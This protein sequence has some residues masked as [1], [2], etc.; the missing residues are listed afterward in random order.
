MLAVPGAESVDG[1]TSAE[2]TPAALRAR[3]GRLGL[4]QRELAKLLGV[5]ATTIAR[6]ERGEQVIG[7]PKLVRLA[8][9]HLAE[10]PLLERA[11]PTARRD[12]LPAETSTLVGREAEVAKLVATLQGVRLLTLT[13][14][15]GVGKTRLALRVAAALRD[16]FADGVWLLDVTSLVDA[17]LLSREVTALLRVRGQPGS[18]GSRQLN[19]LLV[20]DNCEHLSQACADVATVLLRACPKLVILCTSRV[21]LGAAGETVYEVPPLDLPLAQDDPSR[22]AR[23]GA[24]RLFVDRARAG[25]H[26]FALTPEN[27]AA[28]AELCGRL[29]GLPLALELAAARMRTL[30]PQQLITRVYESVEPPGS[31]QVRAANRH[32]TMRATLDWSYALV[33]SRAQELLD[34]LSVFA[35]GASLA[36]VESVCGVESTCGG[37]VVEPLERLVQASLVQRQA[38]PDRASRFALLETIRAYAAERLRDRGEESTIR[39][40]HARYYA[41]LPDN[42]E[43]NLWGPQPG[44]VVARL[45]PEIDNLRGAAAWAREHGDTRLG[46]QLVWGF[47]L[48]RA[49]WS[50]QGTGPASVREVAAWGETFLEL[51]RQRDEAPSEMRGKALL[52]TSYCTLDGDPERARALALEAEAV[53]GSLNDETGLA[54]A[55]LMQAIIAQHAGRP[56]EGDVYAHRALELSQHASSNTTQ[57]VAWILVTLGMVAV[58]QGQLIEAQRWLS[59]ALQQAR[60]LGAGHLI[61]RVQLG[62]AAIHSRKGRI[63]LAAESYRTILR[64]SIE[65]QDQA[66]MLL[67][68]DGMARV[69]SFDGRFEWAA[70]TLGAADE[71]YASIAHAFAR[72]PHDPPAHALLRLRLEVALGRTGFASLTAEGRAVSVDEIIASALEYRISESTSPG[73]GRVGAPRLTTRE[74]EVAALVAHGVNNRHIAELLVISERTVET[75]VSR[76]LGKLDLTSRTQLASRA[77]VFQML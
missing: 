1:A 27:A 61:P 50:R 74:R 51:A 8:L 19:A 24:V 70:R 42:P 16:A 3:R 71:L 57:L 52:A 63:H 54:Y 67:A 69:A 22:V 39:Q 66:A 64:Q 11:A 33:G 15:G 30:T 14:P 72:N 21:V 2:L 35:G 46:F 13:G 47:G 29:D 58:Q 7:A 25:Q 17:S 76:L 31:T 77:A 73:A 10:G 9:D 62:F 38:G 55:L 28:V 45:A 40:R 65:D 12:N 75:H 36:A 43:Y 20:L 32:R 60:E 53:F 59:Q 4:S 23:S 26:N 37:D 44:A 49:A 48:P 6:W 41:G 68:L 34:R 18:T 5:T 56:G